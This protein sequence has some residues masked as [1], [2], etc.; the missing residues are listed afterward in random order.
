[1]KNKKQIYWLVGL[2]A[3][4]GIVMFWNRTSSSGGG[5]LTGA[6]GKFQPLKVEDP[7]LRLDLLEKVRGAEYK[8]ANKNIFIYGPA[9]AAPG[10]PGAAPE[11]V[12]EARRFVGPQ[13]PPPPPALKVDATFFGYAVNP[14]TQNRLAFFSNTDDVFIVGEGGTLLNRFRLLKIGNN[15]ADVEEINTGRRTTME[16]TQP[17]AAGSNPGQPPGPGATD[18]PG[19]LERPGGQPGIPNQPSPDQ[20]QP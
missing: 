18:R 13:L 2:L 15:S 12:V 7:Q 8:G 20:P 14:Q 5:G 19:S 17:D 3:V 4:F 9:L 10:T 11:K 6:T 1:M 16:M